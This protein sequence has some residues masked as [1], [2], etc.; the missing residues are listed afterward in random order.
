MILGLRPGKPQSGP[1]FASSLPPY[2]RGDEYSILYFHFLLPTFGY[3]HLP[4]STFKYF[5]PTFE[6]FLPTFECF[7]FFC[8]P[9]LRFHF[10]STEGDKKSFSI[11]STFICSLAPNLGNK[12]IPSRVPRT[13]KQSNSTH[14]QLNMEYPACQDSFQHILTE[15][16]VLLP[17][18]LKN[19][20]TRLRIYLQARETIH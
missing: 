18:F 17:P 14:N 5:L 19:Q 6:Y 10:L 2:L 3:F 8:L 16:K 11:G 15:P 4:S 12:R 20:E 9:I 7:H 1:R 13:E